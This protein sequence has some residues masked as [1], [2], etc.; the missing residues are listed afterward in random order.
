MGFRS[1]LPS[2]RSI[3]ELADIG[4]PYP[5]RA[6]HVILAAERFCFNEA[7]VSFLRQ[8]SPNEVF[9]DRDELVARCLALRDYLSLQ[10]AQRPTLAE[11][12]FGR[13]LPLE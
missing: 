10:P 3:R 6:R 7:V 13:Y 2:V 9:L 5:M 1:S 12:F 8:F 4:G 11:R